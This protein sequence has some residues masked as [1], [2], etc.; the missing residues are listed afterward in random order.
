MYGLIY[1]AGHA[2][3][4]LAL[5][6]VV[7]TSLARYQP[8]LSNLSGDRLNELGNLLLAAVMFW[9]YCSFFQ[10]LVIWSGNLPEENVWYVRRSQGGWQYAAVSLM[11]LHF[12]VPFLLLLSRRQK[13]DCIALGRIAALL[14]AM[15]FVDVT[16][17]VVPGFP[18]NTS[19]RLAAISYAIGGLAM[20]AI[21]AAWISL[22]AWRLSIRI[23]LPMFADEWK[24]GS[25]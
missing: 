15:R 21:G 6:I 4:G 17:L 18:A 23:R 14:L 7:V 3:A 22:F 24:E 5:A 20:V 11:T 10:Y 25:Q 12:A 19:Y 13:R 8:W 1:I 9:A 2:V 16:W